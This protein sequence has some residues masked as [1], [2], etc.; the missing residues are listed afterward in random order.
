MVCIIIYINKNIFECIIY[1][2]K[3]QRINTLNTTNVL[4]YRLFKKDEMIPDY[5]TFTKDGSSNYE[6][7]P[8]GD[9]DGENTLNIYVNYNLINKYKQNATKFYEKWNFNLFSSTILTCNLS[10]DLLN[11]GLTISHSTIQS[12]PRCRILSI[13]S[14]VLLSIFVNLLDKLFNIFI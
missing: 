8:F 2:E 12:L 4:A 1:D 7:Y 3:Q 5:A 11:W 9:I 6:S 10:S 13:K 14:G